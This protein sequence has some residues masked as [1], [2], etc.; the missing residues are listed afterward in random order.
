MFAKHTFFPGKDYPKGGQVSVDGREE[1]LRLRSDVH[2]VDTDA[3]ESLCFRTVLSL[4]SVQL[5]CRCALYGLC[6][7]FLLPG[8]FSC[9]GSGPA[10]SALSAS[11]QHEIEAFI[12]ERLDIVEAM[13]SHPESQALFDHVLALWRYDTGLPAD[14]VVWQMARA[15]PDSSLGLYA[16]RH[17][18]EQS[19]QVPGSRQSCVDY[20]MET[21]PDS[22]LAAMAFDYH[23]AGLKD[24]SAREEL[25]TTLINAYP[26]ARPGILARQ[27]RGEMKAAAGDRPGSIEDLIQVWQADPERKDLIFQELFLFWLE[28]DAWYW[29]LLFSVQLKSPDDLKFITDSALAELR[30]YDQADASVTQAD[31]PH[32][33]MITLLRRGGLILGHGQY[34]EAVALYGEALELLSQ[35][36]DLSF[37]ERAAYGLAVYLHD[38][39]LD[40]REA[41]AFPYTRDY[42]AECAALSQIRK[43]WFNAI[44]SDFADYPPD[45]RASFF[46]QLILSSRQRKMPLEAVEY[47]SKALDQKDFS[48]QWRQ[49]FVE[50]QASTYQHD[51]GDSRE[52][53]RLYE[54]FAENETDKSYKLLAASQYYQT[55]EYVQ[56]AETLEKMRETADDFSEE[57][58]GLIYYLSAMASSKLGNHNM[59]KHYFEEL[60]QHAPQSTSAPNAL[61]YLGCAAGA[62]GR[63][64]DFIAAMRRIHE[65]YPDSRYYW[66]AEYYIE[67]HEGREQ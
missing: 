41:Q 9:S 16:L 24:D 7:S 36:E 18:L 62:E 61:W 60:L 67:K 48:S 45:L 31:N 35:A 8:L 14:I 66:Q 63:D 46:E 6:L 38:S 26:N 19:D 37:R 13:P 59:S 29:P 10:Q 15:L 28:A 40:T 47:C 54:T 50:L 20:F 55:G 4:R 3:R 52:V 1:E 11:A 42:E 32:R 23:Y 22:R 58:L 33:K 51:L 49:Q 30:F 34:L 27:R 43:K 25:L 64:A 39:F 2:G 53:V 56:C 57:E 21:M 12:N 5:L 17:Y 65:N 44:E